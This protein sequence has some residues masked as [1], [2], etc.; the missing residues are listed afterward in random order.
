MKK[1]KQSGKVRKNKS[2]ALEWKGTRGMLCD[3]TGRGRT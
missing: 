1:M 3:A 2:A